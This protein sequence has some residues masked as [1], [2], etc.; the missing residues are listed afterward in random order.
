M[1]SKQFVYINLTLGALTAL[2]N[3]GAAMMM[4][5]DS[6][7]WSSAQVGEAALFASI[8]FVLV[9]FGALAIARRISMSRSLN[10]QAGALGGLLCLLTFWGVTILLGKSDQQVTVSWMVGVLSGLAV[11]LYYLLRHASDPKRFASLRP[12][13]FSLCAVAIV[14]DVGVFA[15]V[16]WS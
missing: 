9:A 10:L 16:G 15:R 7:R 8:G 4:L 1:T 14:V 6:S 2:A 3:G 5:A 13:L 11:Y 12:M